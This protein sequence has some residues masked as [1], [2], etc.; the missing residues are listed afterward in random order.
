MKMNF[1]IL[2]L[3]P[4]VIFLACSTNK[5]DSK[6]LSQKKEHSDSQSI[7]KGLPG[8]DYSYSDSSGDYFVVFNPETVSIDQIN[9]TI[10]KRKEDKSDTY[11]TLQLEKNNWSVGFLKKACQF[12]D[13]DKDGLVEPLFVYQHCEEGN[14]KKKTTELILL[15]KNTPLKMVCFSDNIEI[16]SY[17]RIDPLVYKQTSIIQNKLKDILKRISEQ[18]EINMPDNWE[19]AMTRKFVEIRKDINVDSIRGFDYNYLYRGRD[20]IENPD[21]S[22]LARYDSL[23]KAME[24]VYPKHKH[25]IF[26]ID[27]L[28]ARDSSNVYLFSYGVSNQYDSPY[29]LEEHVVNT[30]SV[31][32]ATQDVFE[33]E[34]YTN[35]GHYFDTYDP[36]EDIT[37]IHNGFKLYDDNSVYKSK[38][39]YVIYHGEDENNNEIIVPFFHEELTQGIY[40][41]FLKLIVKETN[42]VI[43]SDHVYLDYKP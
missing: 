30:I 16:A 22:T 37:S 23:A 35:Q 26:K 18:Y 29:Y 25:L 34:L 13:L 9:A 32:L 7:Q 12:S 17:M 6:E 19:V 11:Y 15:Y 28:I 3:V 4:L 21:S 24:H 43:Y 14:E 1:K 33:R 41:L 20:L 31:N 10:F 42:E 39:Q 38:G 40:L 5:S 36:S 27:N 8:F 2:S